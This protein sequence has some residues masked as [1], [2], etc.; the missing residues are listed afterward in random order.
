MKPILVTCGDP[1]GIG[2]EIIL[3]SAALQDWSNVL[4]IG[5]V[6]HFLAVR[7]E[8]KL[9]IE[10]HAVRDVSVESTS[11]NQIHVLDFKF[12]EPREGR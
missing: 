3:K 1:N 7:E 11:A 4:A 6:E 2:P 10:I 8:L 12:P 9:D 5:S